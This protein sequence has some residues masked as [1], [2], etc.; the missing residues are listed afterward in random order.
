MKERTIVTGRLTIVARDR[1]GRAVDVRA[2]ANA[3][4]DVGTQLLARRFAGEELGR[5]SFAIAVGTGPVAE[6]E[7]KQARSELVAEV[8]RVSADAVADDKKVTVSATLPPAPETQA[9][10][11]A[12]I[13]ITV[14]GGSENV[15]YNFVS[16]PEVNRGANMELTLSWDI[17]FA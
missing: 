11:E 10:V 7:D 3:I 2:F 5:P 16:F 6:D 14:A 9:L 1:G 13:F 4:T 12:G 15:L 17:D 8:D